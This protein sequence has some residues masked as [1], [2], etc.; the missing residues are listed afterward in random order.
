MRYRLRFSGGTGRN[1]YPSPLD[2]VA[3]GRFDYGTTD[4]LPSLRHPAGLG[5]DAE[6]DDDDHDDT[7]RSGHDH[8]HDHASTHSHVHK[9]TQDGIYPS[10]RHY[11]THAHTTTPHPH[12]HDHQ[13]AHPHGAT[14]YVRLPSDCAGTFLPDDGS[15]RVERAATD[16]VAFRYVVGFGDRAE[17]LGA[18]GPDALELS[19]LAGILT[20]PNTDPFAFTDRATG[21]V[22]TVKVGGGGEVL[23][24]EGF[25]IRP[26][27]R[28]SSLLPC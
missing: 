26:R 23:A 28:P 10:R 15:V 16:L 19:T 17:S 27:P 3:P 22:D 20:L 1:F 11:H 12:A 4:S 6:H 5:L 14:Y 7:H 13:R 25:P 21:V 8:D 18:A 2:G 24:P 9:H